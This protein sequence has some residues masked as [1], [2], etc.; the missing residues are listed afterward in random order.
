MS[1]APYAGVDNLDVMAAFAPKY[2]R[3]LVRMAQTHLHGEKTVVDFGAGTGIFAATLRDERL[4]VICVEPD[5]SLQEKLKAKGL[6]THASLDTLPERSL[7][8]VFTFN[9]LEHI[10]DDV[11][12]MRQIYRRL[13]PGGRLL[14]YVPAFDLLF[15]SMDRKVGHFRRYTRRRLCF[16]LREV[17]F[18]IDHASYADSLGFIASLLYKWFGNDRG[19]LNPVALRT[20]DRFVF[21][22]S[23]ALDLL[24]H[25]LIGK[26]LVVVARRPGES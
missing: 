5:P 14:V 26:N 6:K 21:P 25:A 24:T 17:G 1:A 15:S 20:Y 10:E 3:F 12:A 7:R 4:E 9:V 16:R 18:D 22:A 19:D 2:N 8:A 13:S 23:R 11:E